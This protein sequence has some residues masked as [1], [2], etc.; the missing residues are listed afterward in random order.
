MIVSEFLSG[1]ARTTRSVSV[2]G[3]IATA[4]APP[5]A[6]EATLNWYVFPS[7]DGDAVSF[8]SHLYVG[9][10]DMG[11]P[12]SA[13]TAASDSGQMSTWLA[14]VVAELGAMVSVSSPADA[15]FGNW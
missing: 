3:R 8:L 6:S 9:A 11:P 14:G 7:S 13:M 1:A 2:A 12:Y 4:S 10:S 15:P 5:A